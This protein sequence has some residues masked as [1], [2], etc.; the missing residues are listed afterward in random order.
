MC[1]KCLFDQIKANLAEIQPE[2][3]QNVQKTYFW[4][5]A[6]GVDGLIFYFLW[7]WFAT[8]FCYFSTDVSANA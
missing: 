2:N 1:Y 5:K 3:Q 6:Q 7:K 8:D 4:E